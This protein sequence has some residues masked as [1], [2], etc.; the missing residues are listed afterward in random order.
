MTQTPPPIADIAETL[1]EDFEFLDD[2]EA[3]YGHVIDLGKALPDLDDALK[4]EATKV[5][6]C[7]SQVWLTHLPGSAPDR[8]RFQGDSDAMIVRGLVA[9]LTELLAD[10]K[11]EDIASFDIEGFFKDIGV[12]DA[13][14]AQRSNGLRSMLE[15]IYAVSRG[16]A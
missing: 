13:L 9:I 14:S 7:A 15:R 2:W 10:Q 4:T 12:A 8:I 5:R 11:R 16:T 3:R 6:G 1:R